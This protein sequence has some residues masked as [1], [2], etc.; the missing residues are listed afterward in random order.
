MRTFFFLFLLMLG[1]ALAACELTPRIDRSQ[2]LGRWQIDSIY[3]FY[4]GFEQHLEGKPDDP[5]YQYLPG[6]KVREEKGR[7]Y[8]EYRC[9][10]REPDTLIY[11]AP[12]GEEIG[13]YQVL[14]LRP[15]R[16]V[17]KRA[18]PLVFAGEGQERFEVRYF[19]RKK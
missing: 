5:T 4:N 10:W 19:S 15:R 2:L 8:R 11:R 16:L 3:R 9:E 17:L 1:M 13:T 14:E 7:D 18:Q 12:E 6:E